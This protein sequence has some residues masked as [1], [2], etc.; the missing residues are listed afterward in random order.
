MNLPTPFA[1]VSGVFFGTLA[2]GPFGRAD[3]GTASTRR[4]GSEESRETTSRDMMAPRGQTSMQT[5]Q[6]LQRSPSMWVLPSNT[7][8]ALEPQDSLH[9]QQAEQRA[10]S[11]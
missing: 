5:P 4:T 7:L 11:T 8:M 3:C 1:T 10:S 6:A 9:S 2:A